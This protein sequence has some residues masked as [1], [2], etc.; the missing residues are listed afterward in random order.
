M[1]SAPEPVADFDD[2]PLGD[3][4]TSLPRTDFVAFVEDY[5]ASVARHLE[6]VTSRLTAG[7]LAELAREA[8]TLI[9]VTG[10]YGLRQASVL[11]RELLQACKAQD[12]G[13]AGTLVSEFGAAARRGCDAMRVRFIGAPPAT[14]DGV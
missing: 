6:R 8:H 1:T 2:A 4:E 12:A 7:D 9:S 14:H 11:A 10:S 13:R 5:L 3:I